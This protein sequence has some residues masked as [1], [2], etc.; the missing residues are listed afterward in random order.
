MCGQ[1]PLQGRSVAGRLPRECR[2]VSVRAG[3]C[4]GVAGGS[5][6]SVLRRCRVPRNAGRRGS[7]GGDRCCPHLTVV[8]ATVGC[9]VRRSRAD[10]GRECDVRVVGGAG[11][12]AVPVISAA[13]GRRLRSAERSHGSAAGRRG[14]GRRAGSTAFRGTRS[15]RAT[16]SGT[17][18]PC[19]AHRLQ[20]VCGR[21]NRC[22]QPGAVCEEAAC[23]DRG[24]DTPLSTSGRP[25]RT[26]CGGGDRRGSHTT[27]LGT[28]APCDRRRSRGRWSAGV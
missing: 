5:R 22:A 14:W 11:G 20:P 28:T 10:G 9:G 6:S 12:R 13:V 18:V 8:P 23:G 21:W 16:R 19:P 27:V 15:G 3:V 17:P 7:G 4:G 2:E 26:G 1:E 25:S 24:P